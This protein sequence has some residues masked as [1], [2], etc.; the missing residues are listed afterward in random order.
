MMSLPVW[1]PGPIFLPGG[2]M[3]LVPCSVG[4]LCLWS[5]VPSRVS[6]SGGVSLTQTPWTETPLIRTVKSG[7]YA[8]Y[9][10]AF[11]FGVVNLN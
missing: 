4:G 10:N 11:L 5:H 7:Q 2:P 9:W 6:L 1:L 3:S 8:S